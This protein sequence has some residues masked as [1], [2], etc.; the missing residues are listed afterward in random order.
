MLTKEDYFVI[1]RIEREEKKMMMKILEKYC[2]EVITVRGFE[3]KETVNFCIMCEEC[4]EG[5]IPFQFVQKV[6]CKLVRG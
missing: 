1:M 3:D 4:K 2:N 6:Y 5:I